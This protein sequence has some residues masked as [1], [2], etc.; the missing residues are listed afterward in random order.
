MSAAE[1]NPV[2]VIG[3][4]GHAK[5]LIDALLCAGR[6][7]VGVVDIDPARHGGQIL[8]V[9]VLGGD[10][11]IGSNPHG[12]AELANGIGSVK[13]LDARAAIY[14]RWVSQGHRFADVVHPSAV[15]SPRARHG[16]GVQIM[17]GAVVQ[18]GCDLGKNVLVNTRASIDHDAVIGDHVH[19][20]PGA[21]LSGGVTVGSFTH[22]GTGAVVIQGVKIGRRCLIAAGAIVTR[23]VPD[24]TAVRGTPARQ[25]PLSRSR[26]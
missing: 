14:D 1:T 16:G 2:M 7:V 22:V 20:A 21:T 8:S 25:I 19:I 26:R 4:G 13:T 6:N 9:S 15:V 24:E 12:R 10:E 17:A 23:D 5:V 3:A 11:V 18:P